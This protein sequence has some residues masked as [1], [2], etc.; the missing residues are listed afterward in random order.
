LAFAIADKRLRSRVLSACLSAPIHYS[1][2]LMWWTAPAAG[3]E[4]P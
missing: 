1:L 2:D 3:D 4:S